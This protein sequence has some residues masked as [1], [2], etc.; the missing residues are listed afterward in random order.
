ESGSTHKALFRPGGIEDG[1]SL[2]Y[3]MKGQVS[4]SHLSSP[5]LPFFWRLKSSGYLP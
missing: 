5:R 1:T 2:G 3:Y 4:F